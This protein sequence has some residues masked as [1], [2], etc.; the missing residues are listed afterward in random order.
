MKTSLAIC[1][2]I[3]NTE[4]HYYTCKQRN[5]MTQKFPCG[6]CAK[7][8]AK[9]HN[10]VCCDICNLWVHIKCNNMTKLCYRKLQQSHEPWDCQKCIKQVLPS[11][12]LTYSQ[13]NSITKGKFVSSPKKI[14][15]E[16][17]YLS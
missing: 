1:F 12:E 2:I 6:I 16:N 13:L 9:N 14:I 15:Q 11:S 4:K 10:A 3:L 17:I 5:N 8:V 7:T